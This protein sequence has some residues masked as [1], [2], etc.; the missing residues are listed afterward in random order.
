MARTL[1]CADNLPSSC[2]VLMALA[3]A[4]CQTEPEVPQLEGKD[5]LGPSCA[6]AHS[7]QDYHLL[8]PF[9]SDCSS[10]RTEWTYPPGTTL[11]TT[12][13]GGTRVQLGTT[14]GSVG[15]RMVNDVSESN[16]IAIDVH[17]DNGPGTFAG[18]QAE[19]FD[20]PAL[21]YEPYAFMLNGTPHVI[22]TVEGGYDVPVLHLAIFQFDSD[23]DKWTKIDYFT[24]DTVNGPSHAPRELNGDHYFVSKVGNLMKYSPGSHTLVSLGAVPSASRA[25]VSYVH[26]NKFYFA[27]PG[28]GTGT[29]G[30]MMYTYDPAT[31]AFEAAF[32]LPAAWDGFGGLAEG[33]EVNGTWIWVLRKYGANEDGIFTFDP[34]ARTTSL[35]G[36]ME[37]NN[38]GSAISQRGLFRVNDKVL[39][40]GTSTRVLIDPVAGTVVDYDP[41]AGQ[42]PVYLNARIGNAYFTWQGDCWF[43]GGINTLNGAVEKN[44]MRMIP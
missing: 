20:N 33:L 44:V 19:V 6:A 37:F 8:T 2:V 4:A 14:S 26:G 39:A 21:M 43:V 35:I 25:T 23:A 38:P 18:E 13:T 11:R 32:A 9:P 3:T 16:V 29:T 15:V 7:Y 10:C 22:A 34:V 17:V 27:W 5:L 1:R 36:R 31:S 42:C 30:G 12:S 40:I 24:D 41:P 28:A